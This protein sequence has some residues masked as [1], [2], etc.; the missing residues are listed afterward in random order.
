MS[1][2]NLP[3]FQENGCQ[4]CTIEAADGSWTQLGP[5]WEAFHKM[6]LSR[7]ALGRSCLMVIMYNG[8]A[9]ENDRVTMQR[10]RRVNVMYS[11]MLAYTVL[12]SI[13]TVHKRVEMEMEDGSKPPHKFTDLCREF[14]GLDAPDKDGKAHTL[15][16]AIIP[17]VSGQHAGSATVTHR[18][19]NSEAA[20]LAKKIRHSA[21]AWFFGYWT[22]VRKYKLSMVQKLM[23]SFDVD[24]AI[25]ARFSVF[26]TAT[27]TVQTEYGDTDEQLE[28][29]E[30][31]LG[32]HQG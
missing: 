11:F 15:F 4:V 25:L 17:I 13:V 20:E 2:N 3:A 12:P 32:I 10:L 16:E 6:G 7:R 5:L 31:D 26:D 28:S 19:D 9:T 29:I 8:R 24:S 1:L 21:P 18:S 30:A 23:E 22:C 14:M 27:L